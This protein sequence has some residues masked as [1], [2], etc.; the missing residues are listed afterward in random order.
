MKVEHKLTRKYSRVYDTRCLLK[1]CLAVE[2]GQC[3]A[4]LVFT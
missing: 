1:F 3:A 2:T 4:C